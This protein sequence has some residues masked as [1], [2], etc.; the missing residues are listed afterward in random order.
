MQLPNI[1]GDTALQRDISNYQVKHSTPR[2]GLQVVESLAKEDLW[3][4]QISHAHITKEFCCF[5]ET[6]GQIPSAEDN[7]YIC[8]QTHRS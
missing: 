1:R 3:K 6:D 4:P 8:H 7:T 5:S 2:N